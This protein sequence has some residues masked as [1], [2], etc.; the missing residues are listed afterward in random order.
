MWGQLVSV[1]TNGWCEQRFK[2]DRKERRAHWLDECWE[3]FEVEILDE[4]RAERYW[5]KLSWQV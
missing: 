2:E 1:T 3:Q 4:E 5:K